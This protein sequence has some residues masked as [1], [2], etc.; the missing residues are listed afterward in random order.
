MKAAIIVGIV[1]AIL[2]L[3][4]IFYLQDI[5]KADSIKVD[6]AS[7]E[8][9]KSAVDANNRFAFDLLSKYRSDSGKNVFFSPYSISAAIA[10]AYE[11]A[12]GKTAD[13]M[14]SVFNFPMDNSER[15]DGFADIYNEINKKDKK[16]KLSSANALWA[17][18]GSSFQKEYLDT[19]EKYYGGKA[20]NVDFEKD[21]ENSRITINKWMSDQTEGNIKDPIP[22]GAI[23]QSTRLVLTNAVYFKGTWAKQFDKKNTQDA[24][25]K[26]DNGSIVRAKMMSL[27]GEE[28]RFD[29]AET[30][31]AQILEM[32]YSGEDISML[33]ILPK[34]GKQDNF[35][36]ELTVENLEAWKKKLENMPV[37]VYFPKYK[38]ET[39]YAIADTL[40]EMGMPTAF[41]QDADFSGMDGKKDL[42]ISAVIHQ[43]YVEVN[44]DGTEASGAVKVALTSAMPVVFNANHPFIFLIQDKASGNILFMGRVADP[45]K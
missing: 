14:V 7:P 44:E 45:T 38:F 21:A 2:L 32:P 34:E 13:E 8:A 5:P 6:L 15:W 42:V 41:T 31:Q 30:D 35:E 9:Q 36:S 19:V 28:A 24:D 39:K 10:M 25:F 22:K 17:R 12:R 40:K 29:Y 3:G 20:T 11:G 43:A 26:L 18:E 16:Y 1:L 27:T 37:N 33:V 4:V 23:D